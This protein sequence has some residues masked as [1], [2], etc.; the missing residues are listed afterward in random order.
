MYTSKWRSGLTLFENR[1]VFILLRFLKK[2]ISVEKY[3]RIV[4]IEKS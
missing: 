3:E 1:K 4:I 2:L